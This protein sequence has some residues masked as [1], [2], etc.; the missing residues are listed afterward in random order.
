V[1]GT[2]KILDKNWLKNVMNI[3]LNVEVFNLFDFKNVNSYYWVSDINKVQ[4]AVPN[5]LTGRQ[6]NVKII[7]DFK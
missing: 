5:Y 4:H 6:F 7:V 2:D 1:N 3:W